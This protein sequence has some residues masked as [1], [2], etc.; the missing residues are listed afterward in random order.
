MTCCAILL[1]CLPIYCVVKGVFTGPARQTILISLTCGSSVVP[2][3]EGDL[4]CLMG[5]RCG[6]EWLAGPDAHAGE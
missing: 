6:D 1:V 5:C 2:L 3:E 4:L